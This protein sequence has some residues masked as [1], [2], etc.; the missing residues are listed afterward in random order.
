MNQ[1][2]THSRKT[3]HWLVPVL[4]G[5]AFILIGIW[6]LRSPQESFEKITRFIGAIILI[7][8]ALQA[9]FTI[10]NRKGIPGWGFQ[11]AGDLFDLAV[12]IALVAD[13]SLLFKLITLFVGIW[14]IVNSI[15]L[16]VKAAEA[17]KH[18]NRFWRGGFIL[19]IFLMVLAIIFLWHPT[20]LG[21]SLAI[22][23]GLAFIIL[24]LS[25]IILTVR[26]RN[27]RVVVVEGS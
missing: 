22:W 13:P 14:L 4:F 9:I 8:G 26:L 3:F 16:F 25:R 11:L 18:D 10:G 15:S 23:T 2:A 21:I 24:G 19:G 6:I 1:E 7:S 12:G 27:L 17:K 5:L 20:L